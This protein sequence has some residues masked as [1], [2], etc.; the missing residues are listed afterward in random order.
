M[1]W[2]EIL[3]SNIHEEYAKRMRDAYAGKSSEKPYEILDDFLNSYP[4][5]SYRVEVVSRPPLFFKHTKHDIEFND[6]LNL[7]LRNQIENV[8]ARGDDYKPP[9]SFTDAHLDEI[10]DN[11]VRFFAGIRALDLFLGAVPP[12]T[13]QGSAYLPVMEFTIGEAQITVD[14][15]A[16]CNNTAYFNAGSFS[17]CLSTDNRLNQ[18]PPPDKWLSYWGTYNTL[19]DMDTWEIESSDMIPDVIGYA[20]RGYVNLTCEACDTTAEYDLNAL[21]YSPTCEH[22]DAT[23]DGNSIQ[24]ELQEDEPPYGDVTPVSTDC[25]YG[26]EVSWNGNFFC[27]THGV[28]IENA[29]T[30]EHRYDYPYARIGDHR[31]YKDLILNDAT[32]EEMELTPDNLR[33]TFSFEEIIEEP[34]SFGQVPENILLEAFDY[35]PVEGYDEVYYSETEG[36]FYHDREVYDFNPEL[37][38]SVLEEFYSIAAEYSIDIPEMEG[39]VNN[40]TIRAYIAE[41]MDRVAEITNDET[42]PEVERLAMNN[43][44][45]ELNE[46]IKKLS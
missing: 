23:L 17:M 12:N 29:R 13:I 10:F 3:K 25:P 8:I 40:E 39:L 30:R 21:G 18:V 44:Y 6:H 37:D 9:A 34:E 24:I 2:R 11:A 33:E 20:A 4:N 22:C 38:D 31:I 28:Y 36:N 19:E 5:L 46:L 42:K 32:Y 1:R 27:E 45:N 43:Y 26:H 41:E 35:E 7:N 15:T 14:L 16:T